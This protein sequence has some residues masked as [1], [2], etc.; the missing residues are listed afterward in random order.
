M[1]AGEEKS[2]QVLGLRAF[3]NLSCCSECHSTRSAALPGVP[4][5]HLLTGERRAGERKPG[6]EGPGNEGPGN[7][8]PAGLPAAEVEEVLVYC[9]VVVEFGMEG[10]YQLVALLCRYYF[11]I[12]RG[13][14]LYAFSYLFDV[15]CA[16][17]GHRENM[18]LR[19][20]EHWR[21]CV[22]AVKL[23]SV[24]ISAGADVHCGQAGVEYLRAAKA[25]RLTCT[26]LYALC[27]GD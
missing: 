8:W 22:V 16:D 21:L 17:E 20:E 27:Y 3:T 12:Y 14:H 9:G 26:V 2:A 5:H 11:S 13:Q 1:W 24:G 15:G 23:A 4:P 19:R 25:L 7:E 6:N 18:L 10:G